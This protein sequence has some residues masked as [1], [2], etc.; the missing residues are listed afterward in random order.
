MC[1]KFVEQCKAAN[2][3]SG[4]GGGDETHPAMDLVNIVGK[5]HNAIGL[6]YPLDPNKAHIAATASLI[7]CSEGV[8]WVGVCELVMVETR[9]N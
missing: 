7:S 2:W 8:F 1:I 3:V 4:L 6:Q 5:S 9:V